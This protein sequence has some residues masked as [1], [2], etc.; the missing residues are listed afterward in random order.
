M[1]G[2]QEHRARRGEAL[3][4]LHLDRPV[5]HPKRDAEEALDHGP[6]PLRRGHGDATSIG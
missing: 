1:V 3:H 6:E 4:A 5:V 2:D